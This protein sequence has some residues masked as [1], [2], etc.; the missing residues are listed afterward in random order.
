M[1]HLVRVVVWCVLLVG[2]VEGR[3]TLV[4]PVVFVGVLLQEELAAPEDDGHDSYDDPHPHV[5][6]LAEVLG[7][8][9]LRLEVQVFG[10]VV[11][12]VGDILLEVEFRGLRSLTKYAHAVVDGFDVLG[13]DEVLGEVSRVV[14]CR[15]HVSPLGHRRFKREVVGG[16]VLAAAIQEVLHVLRVLGVV[17]APVVWLG[18]M[19]VTVI[20]MIVVIFVVVVVVIVVVHCSGLFGACKTV[21]A[22]GGWPPPQQLAKSNHIDYIWEPP[23]VNN[24]PIDISLTP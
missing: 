7:V 8:E 18:V 5:A 16:R 10:L 11:V 23:I 19:A 9:G 24:T 2:V 20:A 13:V 12:L 6:L 4:S 21:Y 15:V 14:V 17:V 1:E 3:R 22:G